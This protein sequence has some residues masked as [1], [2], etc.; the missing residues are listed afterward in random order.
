MAMRNGHALTIV[1][2]IGAAAALTGCGTGSEYGCPVAA[3]CG[4]DPTGTW[5]VGGLC[6]H[7]PPVPYQPLSLPQYQKRPQDP[8]INSPPP[9]PTTSG[10][11]CSGLVYNPPTPMTLEGSVAS[12]VPWH[13]APPLMSGTLT[14][15]AAT[16]TSGPLYTVS[17]TFGPKR[18]STHFGP[19]CLQA[20]G[21]T[22]TCSQLQDE[23]EVFFTNAAATVVGSIPAYSAFSCTTSSGDGGCDCS[24]DYQVVVTD[25]GS[26]GT[27]GSVLTAKSLIIQYAY[28]GAQAASVEP[29]QPMQATFCVNG[30]LTMTGYQGTSLFDVIG[31]RSLTL[32]K[33]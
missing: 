6:Q 9:T 12:V 11:W 2:A 33:M 31:L 23:L 21:F 22:P 15:A 8:T 30:N 10:D 19:A 28:D 24:Y 7:T 20:N 27:D 1:A 17:F 16:G 4:G 18:S 5:A 29:V 25:Q 13:D 26:W 32:T 14:F 3:S